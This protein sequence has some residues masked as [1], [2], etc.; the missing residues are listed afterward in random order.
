M[1]KRKLKYTDKAALRRIIF[2]ESTHTNGMTYRNKLYAYTWHVPIVQFA[3]SGFPVL[4]NGVIHL[5]M[6]PVTNKGKIYR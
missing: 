1:L 2:A 4:G 6:S 3:L 5:S